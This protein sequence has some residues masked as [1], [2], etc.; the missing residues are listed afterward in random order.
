MQQRKDGLTGVVFSHAIIQTGKYEAVSN[1][2]QGN[3]A[4]VGKYMA[5]LTVALLDKAQF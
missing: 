4:N 3:A 1:T 5:K 2:I